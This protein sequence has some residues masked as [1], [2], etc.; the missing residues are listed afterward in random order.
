LTK[1]VATRAAELRRKNGWKLPD[2]LQAAMALRI[3]VKLV[4]RNSRD[5]DKKKHPFIIIP[6]RLG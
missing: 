5:F 2:A 6:Y 3:G 1:D 4:T